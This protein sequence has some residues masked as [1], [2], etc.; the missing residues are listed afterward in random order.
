MHTQKS[1]LP[2]VELQHNGFCTK[3]YHRADKNKNGFDNFCQHWTDYQLFK[4]TFQSVTLVF[5]FKGLFLTFVSTF[6]VTSEHRETLKFHTWKIFGRIGQIDEGTI[7]N[8]WR[9][10]ENRKSLTP[11]KIHCQSLFRFKTQLNWFDIKFFSFLKFLFK[12]G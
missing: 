4:F 1:T 9:G 3:R 7:Q 6:A 11:K 8:K 2:F 5:F 10:E 12:F